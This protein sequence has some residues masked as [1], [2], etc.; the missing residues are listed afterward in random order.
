M[1]NFAWAFEPTH[2]LRLH[3]DCKH[4]CLSQ[5]EAASSLCLQGNASHI[6]SQMKPRDFAA[7]CAPFTFP[8]RKNPHSHPLIW[9]LSPLHRRYFQS[10]LGTL[11]GIATLHPDE[12]ICSII[13]I[14]YRPAWFMLRPANVGLLWSYGF[15][16][17][18]CIFAKFRVYFAGSGAWF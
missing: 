9:K 2:P 16:R 10:I 11:A 18:P 15:T 13:E 12:P 4:S 7:N 5:Q 3:F 1:F 8:A 17:A 14:S 6:S